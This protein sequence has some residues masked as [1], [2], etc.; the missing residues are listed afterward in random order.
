MPTKIYKL[1]SCEVGPRFNSVGENIMDD[2]TNQIKLGNSD[3][4]RR[5]NSAGLPKTKALGQSEV[6]K[7]SQYKRQNNLGLTHKRVNIID[8]LLKKYQEKEA[9]KNDAAN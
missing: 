9:K 8:K 6:S 2:P 5:D 7:P 3:Y 1:N 4:M